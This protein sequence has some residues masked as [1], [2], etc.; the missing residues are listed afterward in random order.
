M[1]ID[2]VQNGA[3][4]AYHKNEAKIENYIVSQTIVLLFSRI[5]HFVANFDH[6]TWSM[7]ANVFIFCI[8][9]LFC[10]CCV[11]QLLLHCR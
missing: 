1:F 2:F 11:M 4:M 6:K 8:A 5:T 9:L 10:L 7:V 3:K